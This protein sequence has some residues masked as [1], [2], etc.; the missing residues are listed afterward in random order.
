[1]KCSRFYFLAILF[2]LTLPRFSLANGNRC[3]DF[4][5]EQFLTQLNNIQTTIFRSDIDIKAIRFIEDPLFQKD[6]KKGTPE[7]RLAMSKLLLFFSNTVNENSSNKLSIEK[8]EMFFGYLLPNGTSVEFKY[9]VDRRYDHSRFVLTKIEFRKR[10]MG[11]VEITDD[12]LNEKLNGLRVDGLLL[13]KP[14]GTTDSELSLIT[15]K[16]INKFLT[17][18]EKQIDPNELGSDGDALTLNDIDQITESTPN[19]GI[20]AKLNSFEVP[21]P[22]VIQGEILNQFVTLAEVLQDLDRPTVRKYAQSGELGKLRIKGYQSYLWD[23]AEKIF[24]KQA[25]KQIAFKGPVIAA[26]YFF[27]QLNDIKKELADM[28]E[29]D[30]DSVMVSQEAS[31]FLNNFFDKIDE[32]EN[33][34]HTKMYS[35]L[36]KEIK[37]NLNSNMSSINKSTDRVVNFY[38]QKESRKSDVVYYRATT[39]FSKVENITTTEILEKSEANSLMDHIIIQFPQQELLIL[40]TRSYSKMN[41]SRMTFQ[42]HVVIRASKAPLLYDGLIEL[43]ETQ[44]VGKASANDAQMITT[45]AK[46]TKP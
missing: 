45:T 23:N 33:W 37:I 5:D 35:Q 41:P 46:G 40:I 39:D 14:K 34:H 12:P 15:K 6:L 13:A 42:S 29:P 22:F 7:Y 19:Q 4:V 38:L 24:F 25:M 2:S 32:S 31:E 36:K 30:I 8:G 26:I 43:A 28:D 9:E 3:S 17:P 27:I 16:K 21:L 10:N 44:P 11:E 20:S 18:T 1:M